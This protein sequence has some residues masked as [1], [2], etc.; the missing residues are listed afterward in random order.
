ME[1]QFNKSSVNVDKTKY[2]GNV[3]NIDFNVDV[4]VDEF[5]CREKGAILTA[6]ELVGKVLG[7]RIYK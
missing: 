3:V 6:N 4:N 5:V 2:I 1:C 7:W